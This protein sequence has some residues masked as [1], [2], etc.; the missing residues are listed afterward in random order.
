MT[1]GRRY[2]GLLIGNATY[3]RDPHS[4]PALNGPLADI[5]QLKQVLTDPQVGLFNSPDVET[6]PDYGIQ[7]LREKVDEFFTTAAR[8]DVLLLYYSGHGQL[9]ERGTLYLCA[10][11]TRTAGLR[12]TALSAIEINNIV[13]GSPAATTV[14]ILDC[15]YSGA[16]KGLTPSAPAAGKGR[17]V[18]TS[19]RSTQLARAASHHGQTSLFTGQLV[20]ALR[21]AQPG[22]DAGHLTVLEVYRQVHHWVTAD[23]VIAPQLK[24]AGE[25]D[26]AIARRPAS[27]RPTRPRVTEPPSTPS[28]GSSPQKS[29]PAGRSPVTASASA[30]AMQRTPPSLAQLADPQTWERTHDGKL[31]DYARVVEERFGKSESSKGNK[32][33]AWFGSVFT[34]GIILWSCWLTWLSVGSVDGWFDRALVTAMPPLVFLSIAGFDAHYR[35]YG[36]DLPRYPYLFVSLVVSAGP[37]GYILNTM[38]GRG[39]LDKSFGV[40]IMGLPVALA[41][42]LFRG[43]VMDVYFPELHPDIKEKLRLERVEAAE[44]RMKKAE[45]IRLAASIRRYYRLKGESEE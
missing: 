38:S 14:I 1:D 45:S 37:V 22:K 12:A 3:L 27:Y 25:G 6:L 39:L 44:F 40:C 33:V 30:S 13:D 28:T 10:T 15:C 41:P 9:D 11:D 31:K 20:R 7:D 34:V 18:L 35:I 16:F 19:S 36:I 43:T 23:A 17:Y 42:Y 8:G 32:A 5:T 26:V 24:F 2:R 29:P 21:S 4:L